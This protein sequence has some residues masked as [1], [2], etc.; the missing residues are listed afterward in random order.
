[1]SDL[2]IARELLEYAL[3]LRMYGERAPGGNE[4]WAEFD[5]RCET[6]LRRLPPAGHVALDGDPHLYL[7]TACWHGLHGRCRRQCKF[8]DIGCLCGCHSQA[9]EG[10]IIH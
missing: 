3:H 1:M 10:G 6:F 7:S 5:E 9:P 2:E 8:C 4:T